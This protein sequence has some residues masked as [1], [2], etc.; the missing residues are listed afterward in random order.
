ML[1]GRK[2]MR[3]STITAGADRLEQN[4]SWHRAQRDSELAR[5]R[6]VLRDTRLTRDERKIAED[7][8]AFWQLE[9]NEKG[10]T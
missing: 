10:T 3:E 9:Q 2:L 6:A 7:M 5:L 1:R 8:L 4:E